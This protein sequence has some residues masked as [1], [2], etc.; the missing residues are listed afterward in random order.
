M[1]LHRLG[2]RGE[3]HA[4]LGQLFFESGNHRDGVEHGIDRDPRALEARTFEYFK[5][6]GAGTLRKPI[7]CVVDQWTGNLYV[8]DASRGQVVV[9]D[10]TGQYVAGFGHHEAARPTDVFIERDRVWVTDLDNKKIHVYDKASYGLINSF[11]D[12]EPD[13]PGYLYTPTNLHVT[14]EAVYVS[15]FLG[16]QVTIFTRDGEYV[17]TIGSHGNRLGQFARP[18]GIAVDRE[19][20][21][22]VVDAAF[23][24]VQVFDKEGQLLMFF[25]GGYAGP[26]Y[27]WLPAQVFIDYDNLDYFR[28]YVHPSFDLKYLIFVTN[29]FGPDKVSV[30]GFVGPTGDQIVTN[31]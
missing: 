11:P 22:Y 8:A 24:N 15:D 1:G 25:G 6:R 17:R 20:N 5:P 26:G 23:Q 19:S 3:D 14:D 16:F 4:G 31:E 27:M 12:A 13:T 2:D 7:N 21:V 9:F 10:T 30:Y 18:K 29:Q 28:R